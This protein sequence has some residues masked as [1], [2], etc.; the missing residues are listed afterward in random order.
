MKQIMILL[1]ALLCAGETFAQQQ[2][3]DRRSKTQFAFPE[4]KDAKVLQPFGRFVKAKANI[5][6]LKSTLCY[7][8]GDK[9]KEAYVKNIL[10]VEFDSVKYVKVDS[11]MARVVAT[12]GYNRLVC[13]TTIDREQYEAETQGGENLPYFFMENSGVF[14][15]LDPERQQL[16]KGLPL[17]DKYYF[18]CKG[19]TVAANE[20]NIKK[21]VRP[22]M[23]RAFKSLMAD[24]WWSWKDEE[25]LRQLLD[26]LPQ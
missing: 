11:V 17:K 24:R 1:I 2:R 8:E 26:Y 7:M 18:V 19:Q 23:K 22:D 9:V 15:D 20:R 14:L 16:P 12:K 21:L 10:G 6:L 5:L 25:S 3:E 4:F 13:V